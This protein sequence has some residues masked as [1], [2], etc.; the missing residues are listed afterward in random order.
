MDLE[1]LKKLPREVQAILGGL[2]LYIIISFFHWQAYGPFGL[3]E[4]HGFGGTITVLSAILF[5]VWEIGRLIDFKVATGS[6]SVAQISAGL[7]LLFFVLTVIT[8]LSH[9][10][11]RAWPAWVGLILA[12]VI[13]AAAFM[14]AKAEGVTMPDMPKNIS[15]GGSGTAA[16]PPAAA[17]PPP[18][19]PADAPPPS[20]PAEA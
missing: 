5:L 15:V 1:A 13:A 7:A 12:I 20:G 9:N 14:R 10:E 3:S 11:F 2:V 6:L 18:A 19:P 16:A 17:P 4:W 8:F